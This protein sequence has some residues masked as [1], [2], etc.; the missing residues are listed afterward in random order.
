MI[1]KAKNWYSKQD[2]LIQ[3]LCNCGIIAI[4]YFVVYRVML[5]VI[6]HFQSTKDALRDQ[7]INNIL[8]CAHKLLSFFDISSTL[9]TEQHRLYLSNNRW[10]AMLP[11][12]SGLMLTAATAAF[13]LAFPASTFRF[14]ILMAGIGSILIFVLNTVRI[15]VIAIQLNSNDIAHLRFV[16]KYH[17]TVYDPIVYA[18][19]LIYIAFYVF[20]FSKKSPPTEN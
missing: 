11:Y 3:F 15:T 4:L 17:K 10:I 18:L 12:C 19:V 7:H 20:K 9:D 16:H 14:R 13:I 5:D 6:P 1:K 2:T 8:Y